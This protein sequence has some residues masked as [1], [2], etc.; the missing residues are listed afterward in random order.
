MIEINQTL[1]EEVS[2]VEAFPLSVH[3]SDEDFPPLLPFLYFVRYFFLIRTVIPKAFPE[4]SEESPIV[5]STLINL[6]K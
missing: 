6:K 2:S 3:F 1:P 5:K 4:C